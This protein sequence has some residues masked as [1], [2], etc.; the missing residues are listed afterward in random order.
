[1]LKFSENKKGGNLLLTTL[2]YSKLIGDWRRP[3]QAGNVWDHSKGPIDERVCVQ[4][5][6]LQE[7]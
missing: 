2:K 3:A 7:D 4:L 1:M 5:L 6:A